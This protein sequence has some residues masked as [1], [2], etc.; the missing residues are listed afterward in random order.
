MVD[1]R[2]C[3]PQQT[4]LVM[5]EQVTFFNDDNFTITDDKGNPFFK[6][7]ASTWSSKREL[8]DAQN[9]PVLQVFQNHHSCSTTSLA[10]SVKGTGR[11]PASSHETTLLLKHLKQLQSLP[12]DRP[13]WWKVTQAPFALSQTSAAD[14]CHGPPMVTIAIIAQV[15]TVT[16]EVVSQ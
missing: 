10:L 5:Q 6:L 14:G 2:F 8:L 4:V 16:S 11:Q 15:V 7:N 12:V 9:K 13:S 1:S 3:Y